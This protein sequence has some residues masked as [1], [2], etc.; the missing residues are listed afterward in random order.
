MKSQPI[1]SPSVG[2]VYCYAV[3]NK[4][5]NIAAVECHCGGYWNVEEAAETVI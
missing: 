5:V 3:C 4:G 2:S 1:G